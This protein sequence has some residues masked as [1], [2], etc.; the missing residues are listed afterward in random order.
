M[1]GSGDGIGTHEMRDVGN[2]VDTEESVE[3]HRGEVF[4]RLA[5]T[6]NGVM[7]TTLEA[8][9]NSIDAH[10]RRIVVGVSHV[11]HA[12]FVAD[13][14]DGIDPELFGSALK[15]VGK[16]VKKSSIGKF[17]LG[18]TS[19][20]TECDTYTLTSWA[21]SDGI[22]RR[23]TFQ[24]KL[25]A[26]QHTTLQIPRKILK[27]MPA[28]PRW[29][30][31]YLDGE[32]DVE[33]RTITVM[34]GVKRDR[35][36]SAFDLDEM[37]LQIRTRFSIVMRETGALVRL[38]LVD[39]DDCVSVRDVNPTHYQGEPLPEVVYQ[40]EETGRVVFKLFRA[41]EVAGRRRGEVMVAR[42]GELTAIPIQNFVR[43]ATARKWGRDLKL[44]FDALRS[45]FFEGEITCQNIELDVKRTKF[46]FGD[47]LEYF[48]L[49]IGEWF[50]THGHEFFEIE[51]EQ[52]RESRWSQLG[53]DS[54]RHLREL[55]ARPEHRGLWE[56]ATELLPGLG[57]D[58]A[59]GA[60]EPLDVK[61]DKPEPSTREPRE[62]RPHVR[63]TPSESPADKG[64]LDGEAAEEGGTRRAQKGGRG[65]IRFQ[66]SPLALNTHLW[67]FDLSTGVLTFNVKHPVWEQLDETDGKH[68]RRNTKWVLDLQDWLVIEVLALVLVHPDQ[69]E[70]ERH[71]GF[72]DRQI[73]V[74]VDRF[75][76][77]MGERRSAS[78]DDDALGDDE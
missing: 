11:G 33:W 72:I 47:P 9:Q 25:I 57:F 21:R 10:A 66:H 32:F 76:I 74:F 73:G 54:R 67:E 29:A 22:I 19:P 49:F 31:S 55:L 64:G 46:V 6:Y 44:A 41:P 59:E 15:S 14:G 61:S 65:G 43:Q 58:D 18:M 1:S 52:T 23:W 37:A 16:S 56:D 2:D 77:R 27:R 24:E 3:F 35:A 68:L 51:R 78:D 40:S 7:A 28:V 71:R 17:G 75:I 53:A 30:V 48:Y 50:K 62:R 38:I 26:P 60:S 4:L 12:V 8:V 36:T 42:Q 5:R 20:T 70:F 63:R 34:Q 45:G 69:A 13:D 39:A